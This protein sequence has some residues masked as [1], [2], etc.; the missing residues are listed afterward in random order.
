MSGTQ[1][2]LSLITGLILAIAGWLGGELI[3]RHR[4][5]VMDSAIPPAGSGYDD[6]RIGAMPTAAGAAKRP[7]RERV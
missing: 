5:A 7:V 2:A 3:F 4:V 6:D 1:L